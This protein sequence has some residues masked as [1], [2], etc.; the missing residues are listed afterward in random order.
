MKI[1][2]FTI[3]LHC[4]HSQEIIDKQYNALIPLVHDYEVFW[5]IRK[6]R[7]P[8]PY[9]SYSQLMNHA[10]ATSP[11]EWMI[12][13]NDRTVPTIAEVEKMIRHVS[14]EG[15]AASLLYNV[16]LM[17]YSKEL[18]RIIGHWD[19]RFIGGGWED[20]D[21][22][23]RLKK[24]N[25]AVYESQE[26]FYDYAEPK[27]PL[28][29]VESKCRF[30]QPHWDAKYEMKYA[31]AIVKMLPEEKYEHWDLFLGK[32]QPEISSTWNNWD[33][34]KLDIGFDRPNSG[35]SGSSMLKNRPV[36]DLENVKHLLK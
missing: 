15:F 33:E 5:N 1:D 11:T 19:E 2:K 25:L 35:P 29:D 30:S 20:R 24:A 3:N 21:F 6:I 31:D 36:V 12:F 16:G 7:H 8:F 14:E 34:S 13:I 23:F 26:S 4:G 22:I 18:V 28:Q 32:K 27:S 10:T 9:P 17:M